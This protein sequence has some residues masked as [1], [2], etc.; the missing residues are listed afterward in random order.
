MDLERTCIWSR[1]DYMYLEQS[2][3]SFITPTS[4][5]DF[6]MGVKQSHWIHPLVETKTR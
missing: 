1:Y 4:I 2:S 3:K 6:S 5:E